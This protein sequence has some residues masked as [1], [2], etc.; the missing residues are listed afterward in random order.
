MKK[1][2][3]IILTVFLVSGTNNSKDIR[4][5]LNGA[6]SY[7]EEQS[8]SIIIESS[9]KTEKS[10]NISD[11]SMEEN[12]MSSTQYNLFPIKSNGKWGY[13]DVQGKV[14]IEPQFI[15]ASEF[16]DDVAGVKIGEKISGIID[17]KGRILSIHN[18]NYIHAFQNGV[19]LMTSFDDE[20]CKMRNYGIINKEGKEIV[21]PRY[22]QIAIEDHKFYDGL[23]RIYGVGF[24]DRDGNVVIKDQPDYN[25]FNFH[26]ERAVITK[27]ARDIDKHG[28][29]DLKGKLVI[30]MEYLV[31]ASFSDGLAC[32]SLDHKKY[33]YIDKDGK[34]VIGFNFDRLNDFSDGL[35]EFY[36]NGKYG[37]IDKKGNVVIKPTF[38]YAES[39]SEGLAAVYTNGKWGYIDKSGK[40]VIEALGYSPEKFKNGLAKVTIKSDERSI[41]TGYINKKGVLLWVNN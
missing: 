35:A 27:Y 11:L 23:A 7:A 14:V 36:Q 32:V 26:D 34:L 12:E 30:P 13:I 38:E 24:I 8:N 4:V 21:S 25:I 2:L 3:F 39:F 33:G 31:A 6:I 22:A 15:W 40:I 37:Y 5:N 1:I 18:Y 19:A 28:Y 9:N 10:S 17:K 41:I 20:D 29:I 16:T